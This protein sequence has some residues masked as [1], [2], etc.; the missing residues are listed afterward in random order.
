MAIA[1]TARLVASLELNDKYTKGVD[2]A[3]HKT[4]QLE[5]RISK[6]GS[7][8][9]SQVG[10]NIEKTAVTIG[11][12]GVGGLVAATKAAIDFED[13]FSG[14]RKTVDAT[15]LAKA[16]LTFDDLSDSIR[17]MAREIP[18]A[19]TE[20]AG[21]GEAAG[22]LGIRAQDIKDFTKVVA[23]LS[24]TTDLSSEDAATALGQLGTTLHLTGGQFLEFADSLV[25]LGNAGAST[26]SQIIDIATRFAAA[27]SAAGL[28]KEEILALSSAVASMGIDAEAG[29]SALSRVFNN[30]ATG[31]GTSSKEAK[32]FAKALGLS[33]KDFKR[34]WDHDALGTFQKFLAKLNTLDQ[35]QAASL[36]EKVGITN[37]R[38][39]AAIR[40]M[41]QNIGFV[42]DQLKIS[43]TATGALGTEAAK[44]FETTASQIQLLKNNLTDVGITIG[45]AVLPKINQLASEFTKFLNTAETQQAIKDFSEKLPGAIDEIAGLIRGIP[46]SSVGDAMELAGTGAHAVLAAFKAMPAWVQTAVITG[47][48]L[49]KLT[50]GAITGIAGELAKGL[51][52]GVLGINAGVVNINAATVNGGGGG[53][54]GGVA[55]AA[56][57]LGAAA[58]GAGAVGV[59]IVGVAQAAA[60]DL[61]SAVVTNITGDPKKGQIAGEVQKNVGGGPLPVFGPFQRLFDALGGDLRSPLEKI[62]GSSQTTASNTAKSATD[63]ATQAA[64][65]VHTSDRMDALNAAADLQNAKADALNASVTQITANDAIQAA[66]TAEQTRQASID[67]AGI[68]SA[69]ETNVTAT[70]AVAAAVNAAKAV[71]SGDSHAEQAGIAAA[72]AAAERTRAAAAAAGTEAAS[73]IREKDL[74]VSLH[75]STYVT[76]TVSVRDSIAARTKYNSYN[77]YSVAS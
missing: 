41:G 31:I 62:E 56:T 46:W 66:L 47:W 35:F 39:V 68:R 58:L 72:A 59:F 38:D 20:L 50:G 55:S 15:Q 27:G 28:S 63:V 8:G 23:E 65:A 11:A 18:I 61:A 4:D 1:D 60:T 48:G 19:A 77:K 32:A 75:N 16:G 12:I 71:A 40:L 25:A 36:L 70:G 30:V 43:E 54:P 51:I 21:I 14:I 26:E 67:A 52:K 10:K 74:S 73:A 24:V 34:S 42:N 22:A 49:N 6:I 3:I 7:R 9:L 5:R 64:A 37:T 33:A 44:K 53:G 2:R 69:T 76:T 13:A 57:G 29:G 17:A 45:D